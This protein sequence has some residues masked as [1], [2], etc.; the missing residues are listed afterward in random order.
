VPE[1]QEMMTRAKKAAASTANPYR[2]HHLRQQSG[3]FHPEC[4]QADIAAE[5]QRCVDLF[6][7]DWAALNTRKRQPIP[8]PPR[9]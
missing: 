8:A 9:P 3:I 7:K 1:E 2:D 4:S 6:D 5:I